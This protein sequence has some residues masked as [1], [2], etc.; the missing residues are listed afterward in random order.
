MKE[1]VFNREPFYEEVWS[2]SFPSLSEKY[3]TS[4]S[5]LRNDLQEIKYSYTS[6]R[7]LV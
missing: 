2:T 6:T 1:I 5:H 4:V 3:G 7:S